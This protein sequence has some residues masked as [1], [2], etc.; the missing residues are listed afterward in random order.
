M[1]H[2]GDFTTTAVLA[3]LRVLAPRFAAVHGNVDEPGLRALLPGRAV[4]DAAGLRIGVVHDAGAAAGRHER[5]RR[6]FP[7]CDIVVYGHTHV[8]ELARDGDLW[9]LNPGS[10]TERR[11]APA[12]T[13]A[14]IEG[15][16]PRLVT[17][18]SGRA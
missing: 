6:W 14:L 18:S 17:L 9:I 1:I 11:R 13:M 2:A 7:G 4:V 16:V 10:P 12:H 15:G 3:D 5:L 8:P